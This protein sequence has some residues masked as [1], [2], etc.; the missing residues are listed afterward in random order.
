[1]TPPK[2]FSL[3]DYLK[4]WRLT[5][6]ILGNVNL[7]QPT[8]LRTEMEILAEPDMAELIGGICIAT[9]ETF[10]NIPKFMAAFGPFTCEDL[11]SIKKWITVE[12]VQGRN[13]KKIHVAKMVMSEII[14]QT[15]LHGISDDQAV[16][17]IYLILLIA[18]EMAH[19]KWIPYDHKTALLIINE[20]FNTIQNANQHQ[21]EY[22]ANVYEDLIANNILEMDRGLPMHLLYQKR[23][24]KNSEI[25]PFSWLYMRTYEH[26]WAIPI[27][28]NNQ[29]K[30][31]SPIMEKQATH[32]AEIIRKSIPTNYISYA[33]EAAKI[34]TQY[35]NEHDTQTLPYLDLKLSIVKNIKM[36][37]KRHAEIKAASKKASNGMASQLEIGPGIIRSLPD[38]QNMMTRMGLAHS[39]TA[40]TIDYYLDLAQEY[41]IKFP[42]IPRYHGSDVMEGFTPWDPSMDSLEQLDII[43]TL[44]EGIIIPGIT[45]VQR[46]WV[47]GFDKKE[48]INPPNLIL[49]VDASASMPNPNNE[50]S[51]PVLAAIIAIESALN[52]GKQVRPCNYDSHGHFV[53]MQT[54]S[55]NRQAILEH[56]LSYSPTENQTTFPFQDLTTIYSYLKNEPIHLII[57]SDREFLNSLALDYN[58]Q[59]GIEQLAAALLSQQG[60]GT[61]FLRT[62]IKNIAA[63]FSAYSIQ[64]ISL[65]Q[66]L[67]KVIIPSLNLTI[68]S[69]IQLTDLAFAAHDMAQANYDPHAYI[70]AN[71]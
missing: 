63:S 48:K 12:M 51:P 1:M 7:R 5:G 18:H 35:Y 38:Y 59:K 62:T 16:F 56:I 67:Q 40:A 17:S 10:L 26:L 28:S 44:R 14:Q 66:N 9:K 29:R 23:T 3:N 52:A 70:C 15:Q 8:I 68:Y 25:S 64:Q 55:D 21:A 13:S 22:I 61:L 60:G 49:Y 33:S 65:S 34:L 42:I 4:V 24:D 2:I 45:T 41:S 31:T 19:H 69:V 27:L 39:I 47:D 43:E 54:L 37:T 50:F 20:I 46:K 71:Q 57:I 30:H 58:G 6:P 53:A 36:N 32:L 11:N